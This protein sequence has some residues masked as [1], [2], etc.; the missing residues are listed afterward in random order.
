MSLTIDDPPEVAACARCYKPLLWCW[1]TWSGKWFAAI[2][3]P[4]DRG[5]FRVHRCPLFPGDRQ[6]PAWREITEQPPEVL[7]AGAD[8]VRRVLATTKD[9][10]GGE[11]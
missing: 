4:D 7:R 10:Q 8:L 6:P 9:Q 1:S 2:P 3:E 5:L 11:Q